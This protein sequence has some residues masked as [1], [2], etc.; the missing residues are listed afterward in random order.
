MTGPIRALVL[1]RLRRRAAST[2]LT[3]GAVAAAIALVGVV[4]GIAL[5]AADRTLERSLASSP[6]GSPTVAVSRFAN[7]GRDWRTIDAAATAAVAG[8]APYAEPAVRGVLVLELI[9]QQA[10]LVPQLVAL[11]DPGR[12]T[13]LLEGRLPAPCDGRRCEALLL[14][15]T[16]LSPAVTTFHPAPGLELTVVGRGLADPAVPF[17]ALD[18]RGPNGAR[19][20]TDSQTGDAAPAVL[21]VR[22]VEALATSP[23]VDRTGRTYFWTSP[24]RPDA[25]H[26]W[27]VD[28]FSRAVDA[29]VARAA[30]DDA[31]INVTSPLPAIEADLGRADAARSRLLL[32]GSLAIAILL[33]F[34][35]FAALVNRADV[36]AEERRLRAFGAS[37]RQRAGFLV[38]EALVPTALGGLL[39]WGGAAAAVT[40]LAGWQGSAAGPIVAGTLLAPGAVAVAGVVL[41][42]AL[43]AIVAASLPMLHGDR[44]LPIAAAAAVTALVLLGWQLAGSGALEPGALGQALASPLVVALPP[45]L[46]FAVALAFL[47]LL[48]PLLRAL[49][50][51]LGRAPLPIRLSL[52]S[53]ARD[54]FRPA[55]TLTLLAFSLGAIVLAIGWSAG[56]ARGVADQAAYRSGLDLRVVELGTGLSIS[57]SVVPTSRYAALGSDVRA[58]PVLRDAVEVPPGGRIDLLALPPNALPSLPGW[59]ADFSSAPASELAARLALPGTWRMTGHR[60]APG[61]RRLALRF[62]YDGDPLKLEAV[63]A[64]D[65]GDF[66]RVPIGIVSGGATGATANLPDGAVGGTLVAL[67]FSN[68]RI[69]AGS[70]HQGELRRATVSFVGLDGLVD[71]RPIALEV[72]TVSTVTVRAPQAT[73]GL[74]IPA[75]V[76]P[77]LA[78][79]A[80]T[81]GLLR[82]RVGADRTIN[83]VVVAR[84]DRFPTIVAATPRFVVVPLD[85]YLLALNAAVP[86]AGRPTEM[87]LAAPSAAR[88]A[89][90]RAALAGATFRYPAITDRTELVAERQSDPLSQAIV[91]ALAVGAL[92]GLVLA[93]GG[94]FLGAAADL[95]DEDGELADLEAQGLPPSALRAHALWRTAWLAGGG[96][97]AGLLVGILLTVVATGALALSAEGTLPIPPLVV[98]LPPVPIGA[99]VA[100]LL[101]IVAAGVAV[102]ARAT[103]GPATLGE[104]R[105]RGTERAA[106][107]PAAL[108]AGPGDPRG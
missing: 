2:I 32:V 34:A 1:A 86:G 37:R 73:D 3:I 22:G 19:P 11:D 71:E 18:Q 57:Q 80:D 14:S 35:V 36:V 70:G 52:L 104:R 68:D 31:G 89:E 8:L 58:V 20:L 90:V 85:P 26:P 45:V 63:V 97:V 33:A 49:A 102:L 87:W 46:A 95:R 59:R 9:D 107:E 30:V 94:L 48:P 67:V 41:L 61:E 55:A 15:E 29:M 16:P 44:V 28:A 51:R 38:L 100:I 7:S 10:G 43:A 91:W 108:T 64:T 56:L 84:A 98:V 39:G 101:A 21:L 66:A 72:R 60:L 25:I 65:E 82:L 103:Y 99:I 93:L 62:R 92:A 13:R 40:A 23:A 81:D 78:A 12:W 47:G 74:R 42:L 6:A 50:R 76:S 96:T 17:G 79:A 88:V 53:V 4:F 75:I 54:P 106:A 5:V 105:T 24:V 77:D 27:T 69:I 83:L